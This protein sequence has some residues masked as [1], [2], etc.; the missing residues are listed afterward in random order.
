MNTNILPYLSALL[1]IDSTTGFFHQSDAYVLAEAKRLGF[2]ARQLNKGGVQV[3]LGGEGNPVV[4]AAHMDAIGLMVRAILQDGR[5][6]IVPVGGLQPYGAVDANVRVYARGGKVYTGTVRRTNPSVHLMT[7]EER[8]ALPD[9]ETNLVLVLDEPVH[10]KAE[11]ESLG[12]CCGDGI[13]L[14]PQY[15][16]T[17]SGYVKSRFLDDKASCACL[18]ALMQDVHDG[19]VKLNRK[20]TLLFTQYEEIGHGG[21]CGIPED[22]VDFIAVDIG[23]VGPVYDSD[24][25]KV[26][27][28]VKDAS[29]PYH[30]DL[31]TELI[32]LCKKHGI[33]YALDMFLPRYG[34][35]ANVA[36]RA[37]Y[38]VRHALIGPGVLE[39]HGYERT[40][41]D[42]LDA[43]YRL[44]V[45]LAA[46]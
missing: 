34:S 38:D 29:F 44:V 36:L 43:T 27:I 24:E 45:A 42:A 41:I 6:R 37:G 23:C 31:V 10:T 28:G 11:A 9:Y 25:Q 22:T 4:I 40:H 32:A 46:D 19:R 18:L 7:D 33:P 13:A 8:A 14:D 20:V 17:E 21:A 1:E 15:R 12:I 30:T 35:D 3:T 26:S 2:P 5:V 16:V 39:T